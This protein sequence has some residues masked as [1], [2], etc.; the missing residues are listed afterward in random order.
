MARDAMTG[1]VELERFVEAQAGVYEQAC[2]ELRDGKKRSHWMWFIFP[3]IRGLGS[4]PMAIR[5]AIGSLE[6]ARAYLKHP[7]LG[8]RLRECAGIVLGVSG[9]AGGGK[10]V[11]EIFGYPDDLKF[12]SSM[13]L[14][15]QAAGDS[16]G[17]KVFREALEQC[18][19]GE[20]DRGTLERTTA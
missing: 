15:A 2:A 10:T 17:N 8:G 18:F 14:F 19:G 9:R 5:F 4:S 16:E 12:H 6:E 13:T 3:Q 1:R 7:V 20:M 11:G